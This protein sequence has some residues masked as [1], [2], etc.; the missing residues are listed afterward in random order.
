MSFYPDAD[1]YLFE[2]HVIEVQQMRVRKPEN[3]SRRG[4]ESRGIV[5]LPHV[6]LCRLETGYGCAFDSSDGYAAH[7]KLL[8]NALS[9]EIS[10]VIEQHNGRYSLNVMKAPVL[11]Q[12]RAISEQIAAGDE[13]N[14][15]VAVELVEVI[16]DLVSVE[17]DERAQ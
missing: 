10:Q 17:L 15:S 5:D 12:D 8:Y 7:W 14:M 11:E 13:R 9:I 4:K 6:P 2:K 3:L 1:A 16:T